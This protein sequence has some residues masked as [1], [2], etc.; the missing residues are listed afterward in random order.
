MKTSSTKR[1]ENNR[2]LV[3]SLL[4]SGICLILIAVGLLLTKAVQ[5]EVHRGYERYLV[6]REHR[7]SSEIAQAPDKKLLALADGLE[8]RRYII[9]TDENGYIKPSKIHKSPALSIVFL[10][11]STTECHYMDEEERF[12]YLVGRTLEGKLGKTVNS[13]NSGYP[14]NNS[15]HGLLLL[16]GKII[17]LHPQAIIFMECI[18]DLTY[19]MAL[20]DYWSRHP[21]RGI[22]VDK[23]YNIIK[24]LIIRHLVGYKGMETVSKDEFANYRTPKENLQPEL[25]AQRFRK[26]IELFVYICRLHN[27]KPVLM[28]QFNRLTE[29]LPTNLEQQLVPVEKGWGLTYAE[30]RAAYAAINETL[31]QVAK[32]Q[33]V[34]LIDL[35]H[36]V[37]KSAEYMYDIVHLNARGSHFVADVVAKRLAEILR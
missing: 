9:R 10:G 7:L 18:N 21:S 2:K 23:E 11:G 36:I 33:K 35:D 28:T 34:L 31:R 25:V 13:Y 17:S 4:F 1:F 5:D 20:G 26:N 22:L 6:M 12:P 3:Y 14:G 27:I 37:P 8:N 32:E 19:Q 30:Y 15:L 29:A 24:T 16:Q